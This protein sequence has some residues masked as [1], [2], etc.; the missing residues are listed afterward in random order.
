MAADDGPEPDGEIGHHVVGS[1]EDAASTTEGGPPS[2]LSVLP[3]G[4]EI[5]FSGYIQKAMLAAR[6]E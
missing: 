6:Q 5:D 3:E 2:A 4:D 1:H